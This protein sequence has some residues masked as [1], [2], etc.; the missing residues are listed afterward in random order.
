MRTDIDVET[1]RALLEKEKDALLEQLTSV[2]QQNPNNPSDWVG[3]IEKDPDAPDA[4]PND[5]AD[6]FENL[7]EH[8]I[9]ADELETRLNEV[10]AALERIQDGTYGICA[11]SGEYIEVDRLNANPAASTCKAHMDT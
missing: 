7:E 9:I 6:K 1:F 8:R 10:N 3:E 2:A 5:A 4:D 11:V